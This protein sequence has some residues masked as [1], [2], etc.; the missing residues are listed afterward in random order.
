VRRRR[1]KAVGHLGQQRQT[2]NWNKPQ[3]IGKPLL[4][5]KP[6]FEQLMA[7]RYHSLATQPRFHVE[8][9]KSSHHVTI[10]SRHSAIIHQRLWQSNRKILGRR[11]R[12]A[13]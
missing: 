2:E 11:R 3:H 4:L 9:P 7:D 5:S 10:S 13:S 8:P 1:R 12:G 6:E